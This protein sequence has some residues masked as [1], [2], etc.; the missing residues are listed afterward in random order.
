MDG[1]AIPSVDAVLSSPAALALC[2]R[3]PRPLVAG[4]IR[5]ALQGLRAEIR[6]ARAPVPAERFVPEAIARSA[7]DRLAAAAASG[8]VPVVNAT[9][10]V[11]HTNLG[12]APLAGAAVAALAAAA[13]APCALEIDLADG[14]RGERD[15]AVVD[16]LR[17]LT[18]AEDALVVNNNAAALLLVLD[19]LAARREVLVSRGELIEIGGA[20][21]LPEVL[22][23]SGA[24]LREVGTTNRTHIGDFASALSRRTGLILRTHPS[25]YRITGFTARPRLEELAAL[26]RESGVPLVEDLGSGALLPLE[27]LGL[28]HEPTPGESLRAGADLVTFSGDKLLGGPQAGL[29]VGRADLIARLRANPLK[30]ALRVDKLT[31]AALRATLALLRTARDPVAELPALR[32]LGRSAETLRELAAEGA[33]LLARALGDGFTVGVAATEAEVGSGAQPTERLASFAV[34]VTRAGWSPE[35]V[36]ALFRSARPAILGRI[37]KGRFLLDVRGVESA[38]DLV[39]R[40]DASDHA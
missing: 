38:A 11:L 1:R 17:A 34:E 10:V 28:A 3:F 7:G 23:K 5:D 18:G 6:E 39:P 20:F 15:H 19:G 14:A 22:A 13:S 16:G 27:T 4:A 25:N 29:V 32:L 37:E 2:E 9:G 30:R 24:V 31:L 26:A 35:R 40:T 8:L 33:A 12:R 21:R 36:A